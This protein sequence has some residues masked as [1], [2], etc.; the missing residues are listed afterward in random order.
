MSLTELPVELVLLIA[1]LVD[2]RKDL[3]VLRLLSKR[4][5]LIIQPVLWKNNILNLQLLEIPNLLSFIQSASSSLGHYV[6]ALLIG[7]EPPQDDAEAASLLHQVLESLP[8]LEILYISSLSHLYGDLHSPCPAGLQNIRHL[9]LMGTMKISP[10]DVYWCM[11]KMP[12]LLELEAWVQI[13][14]SALPV[15]SDV[16]PDFTCQVTHLKLQ[17]WI[18]AFFQASRGILFELISIPTHLRSLILYDISFYRYV[19]LPPLVNAVASSTKTLQHFELR[20]HIDSRVQVIDQFGAASFTSF[21]ALD[22]LVLP[23]MYHFSPSDLQLPGRLP[24]Q[25]KYIRLCTPAVLL[26]DDLR[27][28]IQHKP[29]ALTAIIADVGFDHGTL[30]HWLSLEF[31]RVVVNLLS[32]RRHDFLV[33]AS[34][35]LDVSKA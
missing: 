8:G 35:Q 34:V 32:I 25:L 20:Q 14:A 1:S 23:C 5:N 12:R 3:G 4:C 33:G 7:A 13:D 26:W 22:T 16:Q 15:G 29:T 24:G 10:N 30:N 6:T 27:E 18:Q 21:T 19:P 28:L 11:V 17:F 9:H 2:K 31:P